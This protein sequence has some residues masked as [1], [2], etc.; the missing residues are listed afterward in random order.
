MRMLESKKNIKK[1]G[2]TLLI[3]IFLGYLLHP[4]IAIVLGFFSTIIFSVCYVIHL[5]DNRPVKRVT[6]DDIAGTKEFLFEVEKTDTERRQARISNYV[7][8]KIKN[9]E[10]TDIYKGLVTRED[11]ERFFSEEELKQKRYKPTVQKIPQGC[12][13]IE[14]IKFIKEAT[15]DDKDAMVIEV[16]GVGMIGYV[17]KLVV[18]DL[19]KLLA[20]KKIKTTLLVVSGGEYKKAGTLREFKGEYRL[21]VSIRYFD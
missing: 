1:V 9:K 20:T 21:K 12:Q 6:E 13:L 17:P 4:S 11:F 19:T 2:I 7:K 15:E 5:K 14:K 10:I 8:R 16:K 18:N 3:I